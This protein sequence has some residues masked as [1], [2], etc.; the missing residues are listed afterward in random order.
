MRGDKLVIPLSQSNM[1]KPTEVRLD[2]NGGSLIREGLES[3]NYT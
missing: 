3:I 2:S 1:P